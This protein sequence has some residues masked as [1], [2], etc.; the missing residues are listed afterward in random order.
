VSL[1]AAVVLGI[2]SPIGLSLIRELGARGISVH[3][4]AGSTH[5]VGSHSRY[6]S[7]VHSRARNPQDLIAQLAALGRELGS[8]VLMAVSENDINLLNAHRDALSHLHL[9]IPKPGPMAVVLDKRRASEAASRAGL[10]VPA[11]WEITDE[12]A[13]DDVIARARFPLVLKWANPL[14]VMT[15]LRAAGLTLDKLRYCYDAEE[16]RGYLRPYLRHGLCPLIQEFV[17]G[18]G[19][20][21]FVFMHRGR[22]LRCFQHR[23]QREWPPEGGTSTSCVS[24]PAGSHPELLRRSIR[25]LKALGWEGVAMVEYRYCPQRK[26]AVFMEINGRFWG[27]LP[28]AWH[29]GAGFAW[30]SYATAA[31]LDPG[32]LSAPI[33][34][35]RCRY[36]I[37]ETKRLLRILFAPK[38]IQNRN[39]RF[40]AWR[41]CRDYV[42]G[43][44]HPRSRYFVFSVHDPKPF[45]ADLLSILRRLLRA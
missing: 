38:L 33:A 26:E 23:R 41:E 35:L 12:A 21:Q 2:D 5:A 29:A 36:M 40:S 19:L 45:F 13:L 20:G 6:L 8:C 11:A 18:H 39:I 25:L 28:L 37:P 3:G 34:G 44:F 4:I 31:G 22:V 10:R 30:L 9:A 43:F 27:S 1:P 17:P 14:A 32:P 42:L 16:L 24:L 15:T 7:R